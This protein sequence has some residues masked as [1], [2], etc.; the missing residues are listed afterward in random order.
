[1]GQN[2]CNVGKKSRVALGRK[3]SPSYGLIDSRS[4]KTAFAAQNRGYDG[5]KKVKGRKQHIIT[6]IEGHLLHVKVHP[7]NVHDGIA[8]GEVVRGALVKYPTLEGVCGDAGYRK[9]FEEEMASLGLTA[10]IVERLQG[11]GW[12]ILPKRWRV[13][14]TFAWMGGSRR[15]SK[16]YEILA[17]STEN[18][19]IISHIFTLLNRL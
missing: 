10:D 6:D 4:V 3:P 9:T 14:R 2:T 16:D 19:I 13:E 18:M 11:A 12:M 17:T 5:G 1:M 7:A 8:G 15:L